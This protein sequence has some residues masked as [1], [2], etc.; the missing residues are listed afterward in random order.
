MYALIITIIAVGFLYGRFYLPLHYQKLALLLIA[1][2][3][4]LSLELLYEQNLLKFAFFLLIMLGGYTYGWL[5][6]LLSAI[7]SWATVMML[8]GQGDGQW[9]LYLGLCYIGFG[10]GAGIYYASRRVSM[11]LNHHWEDQI[12][13]QSKQLSIIKEVGSAIQGTFELTKLLHIILTAITAGF[14]HGF[15]RAMIFLVDDQDQTLKGRLGVGSM[16]LDDGLAKWGRLIDHRMN[17]QDFIELKEQAL[18]QDH[19]LNDILMN[20]EIPLQADHVFRRALEE[21]KSFVVKQPR[22]EFETWLKDTFQMTVFGVVPM[23]HKG[24]QV[25]VIV[26]DNNISSRP[27]EF[28][29]IDAVIPLA[30]QASVAIENGKLYEE[31]HKNS[32]TDGLTGLY[33]QRYF[34]EMLPKWTACVQQE[35]NLSLILLDIDFFKHYNDTN[36]HLEGNQVLSQL[37]HLIQQFVKEYDLP[38]RF[39]GEEF[40][41]ILP[42]TPLDKAYEY[43]E[44]LRQLIETTVFPHQENQ[45]N[46]NLTVSMGVAELRTAQSAEVLVE[47]ADEALYQAKKEGKNQVQVYKG[48]T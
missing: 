31:A 20:I 32:I 13:K 33:N 2:S 19:D 30:V 12:F 22:G 35:S 6:G 48:V 36:G 3:C 24:K 41:I 28:D 17:L 29:D 34:Q 8:S 15:N 37:G 42:E 1:F 43:A 25:G 27:I 16:S 21:Q 4:M 26:I 45:P 14:G 39:G 7:V 11:H 18:I 10:I 46:G 38:C 23:L 44:S 47:Q 5:G 9:V 40:S